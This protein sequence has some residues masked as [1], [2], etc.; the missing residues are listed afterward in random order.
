[1]I[2]FISQPPA[3]AS[4]YVDPAHVKVDDI[5]KSWNAKGT[6]GVIPASYLEVSGSFSFCRTTEPFYMADIVCWLKLGTT[7]EHTRT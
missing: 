6:E 7:S 3:P 2:N 1:L 4:T 5:K